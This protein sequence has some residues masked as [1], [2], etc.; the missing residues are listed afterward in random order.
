MKLGQWTLCAVLGLAGVAAV[1]EQ[2]SSF[3]GPKPEQLMAVLNAVYPN[4]NAINWQVGDFQNIDLD[5]AGIMKGTASKKVTKEEPAQNAVWYTNT[6]EL[7]GQKQTVETLVSRVDGKELKRIVNGKEEAPPTPGD[8]DA[9]LE[10][11]EQSETEITVPA[12]KFECMYIKAKITSKGQSQEMEAW[13]N[14]VAVNIDGMIKIVMAS[15][16][17]PISMTLKEFGPRH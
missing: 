11:I 12:G 15:Q 17:G 5:Y 3:A 6:I 9:S 13:M 7:M 4:A 1:A 8:G 14:P 2:P 10:I 16:L